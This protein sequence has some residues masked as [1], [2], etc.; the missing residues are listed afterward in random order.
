MTQLR[1]LALATGVLVLSSS[2]LAQIPPGYYNSVDDTNA[3]TLRATLHPVI[4]DHQRFPYTAGGTDTVDILEIAQTNPVSGSH[5]LDIYRNAS[6]AKQG[7]AS[8]P[9]NREHTWPSSY[10]F[11]DDGGTNYPFTDCHML[12]LCDSGYNTSRSNKPFRNC[13]S[14]CSEQTTLFNNGQ[15]GGSGTHPGNSNWTTGSFTNGTWEVWMGRR[16]DIARTMFYADLRYEGGTHNSSGASEP[17]LRLTDSTTLINNS[18]TG[19]N[20]SV[21]YMGL[22]SVLLQ[23]HAEDPVDSFEINRNNAVFNFQGNRNPFVDHPE[24]VDCIYNG[25]CTPP[26]MSNEYCFGDGGDQMGCRPC[27]CGNEAPIGT[28]GGCL[29]STGQSARLHS[30]GTPSAANDTQ[31]FEVTGANPLTFALLQ[32]GDN[33]LP[34]MGVCPPGSGLSTMILDGLRCMG[35][36]NLRHGVRAT[37][38]NGDIGVGNLGWGGNDPPSIGLMLQGGFSV[39]QTRQFQVFYRELAGAVCMTALNTSSAIEVTFVP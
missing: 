25:A 3:V 9:Y 13:S 26:P 21:A 36:A 34:L 30:S 1:L 35:G 29:N 7:N 24:W 12:H 27:P 10:G 19:S 22:L 11:P 18:N 39:G 33:K 15:G 23:W 32:S 2:A 20:E 16:G 4:D 37:D 6:Y 8:G 38:V 28:I 31:R 14:S 5:I 17:D